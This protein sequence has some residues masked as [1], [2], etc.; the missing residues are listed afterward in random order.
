MS[1]LRLPCML[2]IRTE[3]HARLRWFR[4]ERHE[5]QKGRK[6]ELSSGRP[7]LPFSAG[8][9][10]WA[11]PL[12]LPFGLL[13]RLARLGAAAFASDTCMVASTSIAAQRCSAMSCIRRTRAETPDAS[14][15]SKCSRIAIGAAPRL[16]TLQCRFQARPSPGAM[17]KPLPFEHS[18]ELVS[19]GGC[20]LVDPRST[21][22]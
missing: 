16:A 2:T 4:Q 13:A 3:M 7:F 10:W 19:A 8:E 22:F 21:L 12:V 5:R 6:A 15:G 20:N 1:L 11:R 18:D 17:L 14:Y 9:R